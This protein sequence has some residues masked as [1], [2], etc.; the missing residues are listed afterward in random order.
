MVTTLV[1][2]NVIPEAIQIFKQRRHCI[3]FHSETT[4]IEDIVTDDL[5][6]NGND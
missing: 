5:Y 6:C 4:T 1:E 2:S 3:D